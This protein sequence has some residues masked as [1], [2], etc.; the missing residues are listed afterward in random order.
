MVKKTLMA[1]PEDVTVDGISG[2]EKTP[3]L[4]WLGTDITDLNR[5]SILFCLSGRDFR[6]LTPGKQGGQGYS[7]PE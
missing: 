2:V 5:S 7:S 1:W 3:R 4:A 6:R